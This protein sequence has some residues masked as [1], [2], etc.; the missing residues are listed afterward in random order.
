VTATGASSAETVGVSCVSPARAVGGGASTTDPTPGAGLL[1]SVPL[2]AYSTTDIAEAGDTP[3]GWYV[4]WGN[5]GNNLTAS[6]F[7]ICAP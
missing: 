6:V 7:A 4:A 3:T 5:I 2:E 1:A